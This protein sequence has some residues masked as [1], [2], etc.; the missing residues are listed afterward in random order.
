M[1]EYIFWPFNSGALPFFSLS[2]V[3]RDLKKVKNH[4]SSVELSDFRFNGP[5]VV[6]IFFIHMPKFQNI[7]SPSSKRVEEI[8]VKRK[9]VLKSFID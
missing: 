7:F 1:S 3:Y 9:K 2:K 5:V 8:L 4:L 6:N